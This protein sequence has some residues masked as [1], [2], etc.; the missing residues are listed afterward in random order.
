MVNFTVR[1]RGPFFR[2]TEEKERGNPMK[3]TFRDLLNSG[4]RFIGTYM[5]SPNDNGLEAMKLA[6]VDFVIFDLEHEQLTLTEVMHLIRT[7][8]ACG[9]AT[10]VRVPGLD[11]GMI[12]KALDMGASAI[13]IPGVSSAEEAALAVSYCK[14]PPEGIRGSCPFVRC[15]DYGTNRENCYAEANRQVVVSV[16][17]E[18]V[19]GVKNLEE[20][21]ATPGLDTISVGNVDL[22][23][24]L[25]VPGQVFHPLVMQAVLDAADLC[26]KYGKSCSVQ[27]VDGKDAERFKGYKGVS[28]Y[29]TDLPTAMLYKAYKGLCDDLKSVGE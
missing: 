26:E 15:N 18:G 14:Y 21:I 4:H 19:E 28:H 13:K 3:V 23:C 20:I 6:G 24:A 25:G 22:S 11:E 5:M 1:C 8:E 17:V 2:K 16:I 9:M 7:A 29:H 10:M 27:V 12:K